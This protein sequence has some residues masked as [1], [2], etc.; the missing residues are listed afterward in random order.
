MAGT[1]GIAAA[2]LLAAAPPECADLSRE[3]RRLEEKALAMPLDT[4]AER[5]AFRRVLRW[6]DEVERRLADCEAVAARRVAGS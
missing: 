6:L 4:R 3:Q 2:L 1:L 5:A